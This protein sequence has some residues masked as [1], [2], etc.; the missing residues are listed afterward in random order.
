MEVALQ[1]EENKI[2][3]LKIVLWVALGSIV[4]LFAG[5]T[6]AYLVREA[7]GNWVSFNLPKA[8][9]VS[10]VL[11]LA[12]SLTI[13]LAIYSV[14]KNKLQSV[15]TYLILRILSEASLH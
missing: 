9:Y 8:F 1:A 11:I 5:L 3:T 12:S 10:T 6:S 15:K 7:E 13:Q 2:P 14:K 4:M